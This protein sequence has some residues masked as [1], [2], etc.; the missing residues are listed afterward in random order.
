MSI[1]KK[2]GIT[3]GVLV[4]LLVI[5]IAVFL[6]MIDLALKA[7]IQGWQDQPYPSVSPTVYFSPF[8]SSTASR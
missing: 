2:V 3:C 1:A 8:P 4:G 7:P 6:Y 5:G